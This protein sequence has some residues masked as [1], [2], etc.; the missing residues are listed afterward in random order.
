MEVKFLTSRSQR[1]EEIGQ[2]NW[3]IIKKTIHCIMVFGAWTNSKSEKFL[4]VHLEDQNDCDILPLLIRQN[5]I[6]S[7]TTQ[8]YNDLWISWTNKFEYQT[9][10]QIISP[11][12]ASKM[13][14]KLNHGLTYLVLLVLKNPCHREHFITNTSCSFW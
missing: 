14:R 6:I 10:Y 7:H 1:N 3:R 2:I 4:Q 9:V 13:N 5:T 11:R 8:K 12:K